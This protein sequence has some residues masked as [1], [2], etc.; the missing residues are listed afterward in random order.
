MP[1]PWDSA[2]RISHYVAA[3]KDPAAE[4]LQISFLA[5]EI[6]LGDFC[7]LN[8]SIGFYCV[9]DDDLEEMKLDISL[10]HEISTSY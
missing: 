1:K 7:W 2:L 6:S 9:A 4:V 10:P 5:S 3:S 8:W